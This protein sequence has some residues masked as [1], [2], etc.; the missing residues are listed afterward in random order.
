MGDIEMSPHA[1]GSGVGGFG[2]GWNEKEMLK[3][4]R[5]R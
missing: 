2:R 4:N 1:F 3:N 5:A